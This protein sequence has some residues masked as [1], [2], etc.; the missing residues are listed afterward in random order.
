MQTL[1]ESVCCFPHQSSLSQS[2]AG[3]GFVLRHLV[4]ALRRIAATM[5]HGRPATHR[6][7][8]TKPSTIVARAAHAR[9]RTRV[10]RMIHLAMAGTSRRIWRPHYG[11]V[12]F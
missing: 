1:S 7:R 12:A 3:H 9:T 8:P 5:G 10:R 2:G 6:T 4:W 11:T